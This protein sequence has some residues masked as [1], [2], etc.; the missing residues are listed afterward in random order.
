MTGG[1]EEYGGRESGSLAWR[2]SRG[3]GGTTAH[4]Q[5]GGAVIRCGEAAHS[6]SLRYSPA[7]DKY[8]VSRDGGPEQVCPLP[9]YLEF[10]SAL[11]RECSYYIFFLEFI[12]HTLIYFVL[13]VLLWSFFV[14]IRNLHWSHFGPVSGVCI[15]QFI[16]EQEWECYQEGRIWL[17][18]GLSG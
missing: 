4:C 12:L 3:E 9:P 8:F 11:C 5:E 7:A 13:V 14:D 6:F 18:H 10:T 15:V 1:G 2:Q 17:E 16:G